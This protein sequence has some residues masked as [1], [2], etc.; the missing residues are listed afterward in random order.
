MVAFD[1]FVGRIRKSSI[2]HNG[3]S[4]EEKKAHLL[5]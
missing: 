4:F 2:A 5:S 3:D 1:V